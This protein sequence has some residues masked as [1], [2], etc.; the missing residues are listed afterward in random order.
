MKRLFLHGL[1][2]SG[3]GT[4]GRYFAEKFPDMLRP[5]FTGS[6]AERMARLHAIIADLTE[7]V[8]VGSSFGGLMATCLAKER[9]ADIKRLV[10]LAPALSFKEYQPPPVK[11]TTEA[12][13]IVGRR[14]T[15]TPPDIVI[16]AAESTFA[17][18]HTSVVDDDHLLH[19]TFQDL[20]WPVL[21][22]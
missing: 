13:L 22:R 1:D 4:K 11:L 14:D 16:P 20:D 7:L 12:I 9:K 6:L 3:F 2:S 18:L 17:S 19:R 21:L 8:I 15:V 10:L 5:D